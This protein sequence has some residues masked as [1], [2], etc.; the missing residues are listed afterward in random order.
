[1]EPSD[2]FDEHGWAHIH[3][4]ANKGYPRSIEKFVTADPR[5]LELETIDELRST[6]FLIAVTGRTLESIKCLLNLGAKINAIN[7]QNHGAVEICALKQYVDLLEF[8]IQLNDDNLPVW[9]NLLRFLSSESEFEAEPAGCCLRTLTQRGAENEINHNWE[10]VFKNNGIPTIIKVAK[11]SVG[12]EA[13]VPA[14]QTLLNIIEKP[15]VKE[16]IFSTGGIPAFIRLLKSQNNLTIQLSAQIIKELV[17][18]REYAD[19]AVQNSAIPSLLKVLQSVK[20][21]EVLVEAVDALGNIA[22][23][24]STHQSTIGNTPGSLQTITNIYSNQKDK[25]LLF[26]LNTAVGKIASKNAN[27]QNNFVELGVTPFV[28]VLCRTKN[29]D[30]QISSVEAIHRIAEDNPKT[31]KALLEERAHDHLMQLLK[32]TRGEMLLEKTAMAL[33]SLAGDSMDEQRKMAEH[34]E[35]AQLIEFLN[36][37]SEDLHYIGSEGLGVLA[38]GPLNYQTEIAN[39][40]GIHPLVRFFRSDKEYIVL[41]IIRTLRHLCVGV[42]YVPHRKNQ[43]TIAQARGVRFLVGLMVHSKDEMIQV[44]SALTL[45]Y[46]SLGKCQVC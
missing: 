24:S 20:D 46:V 35:V 10:P 1:M 21:A 9:K 23:T 34:I 37:S 18:I 13:K 5:Q 44:E 31:Q 16:Q 17:V 28:V 30:L 12:D 42:G 32:K 19:N 36:S 27:N 11:S 38:Q 26:S 15:E 45:G 22:E 6:P 4:A 2:D 3:N 14:L 33:W 41:S 25:D 8:F 29:R 43:T 7:S 39:A 40:N